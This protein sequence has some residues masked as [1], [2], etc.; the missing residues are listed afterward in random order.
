MT[1]Q[2]ATAV[3]YPRVTITPAVKTLAVGGKAAITATLSNAT[4]SW[5]GHYTTW[6]SSNPAV[7]SVS[8]TGWGKSDVG[9]LVGVKAGTATIYGTTQSNTSGSITITVGS[10]TSTSTPP[11]PP[12]TSAP[13]PANPPTPTPAPVVGGSLHEPAGMA[14]QFNTGAI[15]SFAQS[16][17]SMIGGAQ[18]TVAP[19][20]GLRVTYSP[21]LAGG[22][23][24]GQLGTGDFASAG[25]GTIYV[26]YQSRTSPGFTTNGNTDIKNFEPHTFQEGASSGEENHILALWAVGS[27]SQLSPLIGLQGPYT[28]SNIHPN[29]AIV[30]SDGNWHTIEWLLVQDSPAG[31]GN[32]T[33]KVWVDGTQV[34]NAASVTWLASGN[35]RGWKALV[36]DPTYGGGTANP[37]TTMYW[38]YNNL[39]VSTK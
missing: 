4:G 13:S 8:T 15:T 26:R 20:G 18:P 32:G 25:T 28:A 7:V 23:S 12:S 27:S 35:Q 34:I 30:V 17:L 21:S 38:D 39:Y 3:A 6:K 10:S 24:P 33:A 5:Y 22:N 11:A 29:P 9:N 16:K 14:M 31:A 2:G 19:G 36:C 37:P 1:A